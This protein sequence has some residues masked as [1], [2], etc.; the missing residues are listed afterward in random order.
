MN[1]KICTKC[2][3]EKPADSDHFNK[4]P[5]GKFGL[6]S[7]CKVC[8]KKY[9]KQYQD[10]NRA[11]LIQQK[12]EYYAENREEINAH[13]RE[14]NSTEEA[15]KKKSEQNKKYREANKEKIKQKHKLYYEKNKGCPEFQKK[16]KDYA[17]KWNRGKRK[18]WHKKRMKNDPSYR[19]SLSLRKSVCRYVKQKSVRTFDLVGCSPDELRQHLEAQW[20]EGMS[21]DNYGVYVKG[22]PMKWHIDHIIPCDSF[23][24]TNETEQ[25]ECFH[26]SNLQPMWGIDNI[27]K[28]NACSK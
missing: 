10:K 7:K 1:T 21:W 16:K 27:R 25:A 3:E 26:Y 28:S 15:K 18:E 12:R 24:L 20:T 5:R 17:Q 9:K 6:N 22:E 14:R 23:D 11:K 2:N 8:E 19:I 13:R 4:H